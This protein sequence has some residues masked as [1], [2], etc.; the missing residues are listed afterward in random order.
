MADLYAGPWHS[1]KRPTRT[2]SLEVNGQRY[3]GV[4]M[5]RGEDK[6]TRKQA[7]FTCVFLCILH[8]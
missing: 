8:P 7:L 4:R 5:N 3:I 2:Q 1:G 6:N